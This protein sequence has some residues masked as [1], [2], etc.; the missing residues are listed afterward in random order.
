MYGKVTVTFFDAWALELG[1][2]E[3]EESLSITK[4]YWKFLGRARYPHLSMLDANRP[5]VHYTEGCRKRGQLRHFD[6]LKASASAAAAWSTQLGRRAYEQY[7]PVL[8][9]VTLSEL[10]E[11]G[12]FVH[13]LAGPAI[14]RWIRL[15]ARRPEFRI[16][17]DSVAAF[18]K[19]FLRN[20]FIPTALADV[21]AD[22]SISLICLREV[23]GGRVETA[24]LESKPDGILVPTV[25]G[26]GPPQRVG[27]PGWYLLRMESSKGPFDDLISADAIKRTF[28]KV[29]EALKR[30][31][32]MNSTDP[33][34]G[35]ADVPRYASLAIGFYASRLLTV[36]AHYRLRYL[37]SRPRGRQAPPTSGKRVSEAAGM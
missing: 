24:I 3:S 22:A 10:Q 32:P 27:N 9:P 15:A 30:C 11:Q 31:R 25:D 4:A 37:A 21:R 14:E 17:I 28:A 8:A 2:L 29:E 6:V 36:A 26:D 1:V 19:H 16:D 5:E 23:D 33:L 20:A 18:V 7:V 13:T 12:W 34:D 35:L